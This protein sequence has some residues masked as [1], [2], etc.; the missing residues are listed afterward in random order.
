MIAKEIESG[1]KRIKRGK[2]RMRKDGLRR[3]GSGEGESF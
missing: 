2:R 3:T 1:E